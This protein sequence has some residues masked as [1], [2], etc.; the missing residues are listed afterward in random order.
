[1]E[2]AENIPMVVVV[3]LLWPIAPGV[4][5][6]VPAGAIFEVH[7]SDLDQPGVGDAF[8]VLVRERLIEVIETG[9]K[10]LLH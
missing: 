5:V 6:Q 1:M 2:P 3:A 10:P 4:V 8:E 7:R 9:I